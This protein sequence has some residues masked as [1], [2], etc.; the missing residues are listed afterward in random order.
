M[1][2]IFA[3]LNKT[4]LAYNELIK[5]SKRAIDKGKEGA[6]I[7]RGFKR[8]I[9]KFGTTTTG[10]IFV[11]IWASLA[12]LSFIAHGRSGKVKEGRQYVPVFGIKKMERTL[13][14]RPTRSMHEI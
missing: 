12:T 8:R 14:V 4:K 11:G 6:M 7:R 10:R 3:G 5:H 9:S 2:K 1:K 13:K